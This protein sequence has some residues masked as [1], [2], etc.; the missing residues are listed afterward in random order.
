MYR[1]LEKMRELTWPSTWYGWRLGLQS[2]W[3]TR[4][5]SRL[6]LMSIVF[7][8]LLAMPLGIHGL[9]SHA[10]DSKQALYDLRCLTQ[11]I[12]H[13]A[14][15]ESAAGQYA[16]A[17]VTLN[18]V[19]SRHFPDTICKVVHEQRWDSIRKRHVGAFSWTELELK[20]DAGD[21]A[22][23]TARKIAEDVYYQRNEPRVED[24]LFYHATYIRPSWAR[25]KTKVASIGQHI[26]YK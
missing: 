1:V 20:A 10:Q 18:R 23:K 17:E 5:K 24:A 15:G 21:P 4:D 25:T 13:E 11:N 6:T 12:Y 2:W 3:Y 26:F 7:A 16:V 14:R 9:I 22:Y 19:A 8:V